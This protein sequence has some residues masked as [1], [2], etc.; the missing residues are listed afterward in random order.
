MG[1]KIENKKRD[2]DQGRDRGESL[3]SRSM[4]DRDSDLVPISR[5]GIEIE[6]HDSD[7]R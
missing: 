7:R 1:K 4:K 3:R 2:L 5:M 6:D